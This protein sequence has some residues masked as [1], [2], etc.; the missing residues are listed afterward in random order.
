MEIDD[1]LSIFICFSIA[2]HS[3]SHNIVTAY[4][5]E[6]I[7]NDHGF[8]STKCESYEAFVTGT[9]ESNEK[10]P[11]GGPLANAEGVYYL[12][13]NSEKPYSKE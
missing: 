9:C 12:Y 13:T 3:C 1:E 10:V 4:F 11:I 2:G 6:S 5:V 7:Q 8:L